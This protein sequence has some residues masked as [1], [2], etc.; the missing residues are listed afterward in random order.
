[1]VPSVG[2]SM[3]AIVAEALR[4]DVGATANTACSVPVMN[5]SVRGGS[6]SEAPVL[7]GMSKRTLRRTTPGGGAG[8]RL[9]VPACRCCIKAAQIGVAP[10]VPLTSHMASPRALPT[11][12]PIV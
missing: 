11:Q 7:A 12:T 3:R 9:G 6:C 10:L 5:H 8:A 4:P 2:L 1:M